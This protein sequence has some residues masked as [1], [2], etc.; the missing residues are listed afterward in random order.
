MSVN[1][2]IGLIGVAKQTAKGTAASAPTFV[3][4]LTGGQTF[5]LERS[6]QSANVTCGIRTGTDSYV[7][8]VTPGLDFETYGYSD[9]IGL[10]L[11][12]AMGNVSSSS[13]SGSGTNPPTKQHVIT[14]G[15]L[16]PYLTFWG[17][18]G[19][20]FTKVSD[21]KVDQLE[22]DFEGN[23]PLGLGI[24]VLGIAATMGLSA[25]PGSVSP[26][27]F[28]GYFVPTGGTF[29]LA[30][31]GDTPAVA[32]V[33]SGNLT[34]SNGCSAEPLA[35]QVTPGDVEEGKLAVSGSVTVKPDD[36]ALYTAMVTGAS[37]GTAPTAGMVYGSFE[38]EFKHSKTNHV[39]MVEADRVP[40][41]CDYP[42]VDPEGGAAELQFSFENVGVASAS[43]SPVTFTL[44][45]DTASY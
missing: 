15:D 9:V 4:G 39:L 33:V 40:F 38:W 24:T 6:V 36:M 5:K 19:G 43:D 32:P 8:G 42:S 29:K 11:L 26:A 10:Y 27:C 31:A 1:T 25:F 22:L 7:E 23:A 20:E 30:T 12:A 16:L 3:H 17:R 41:T 2:S 13:Y 44:L 21:C 37:D 28:D 35:G 34:L 14:M 45:N 18:I